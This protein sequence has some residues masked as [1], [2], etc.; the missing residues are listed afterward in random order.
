MPQPTAERITMHQTGSLPYSARG[1]IQR[2]ATTRAQRGTVT[3]LKRR[4][5]AMLGQFFPMM[6]AA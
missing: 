3:K 4:S 1:T 2:N 6:V 5:G